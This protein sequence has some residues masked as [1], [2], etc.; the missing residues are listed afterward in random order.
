[1]NQ[2]KTHSKKPTEMSFE[3]T[4]ER[5][6]EGDWLRPIL[7]G[8]K[9]QKLISKAKFQRLVGLRVHELMQQSRKAA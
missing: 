1:M 8:L 3:Q 9:K 4:M 6:I 5:A 7:R 2:N